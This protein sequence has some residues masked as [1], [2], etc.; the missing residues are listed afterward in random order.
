MSVPTL[1]LLLAHPLLALITHAVLSRLPFTRALPRQ[2]VALLAGIIPAAA[3]ASGIFTLVCGLLSAHVYFHLF[4]MSETA[5]RIHLL[6]ELRSRGEID[7]NYQPERMLALR[8]NRLLELGLLER[9]G[10]NLIARPSL[11]AWAARVL[12]R[13]ERILFPERA[14]TRG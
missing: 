10:E 7:R 9:R 5:R 4:N 1:V 12:A 6:T 8:L 14:T 11:L 3:N 13:Y 2:P